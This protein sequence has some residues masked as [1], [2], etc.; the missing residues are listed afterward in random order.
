MHIDTVILDPERTLKQ[1]VNEL[2]RYNDKVIF[3]WKGL[4]LI[5]STYD[6]G[7][8]VKDGGGVVWLSILKSTGVV[9]VAGA[10]W[11]LL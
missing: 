3:S 11:Q 4:W 8:V 10:S 6:P 7:D 1:C 9:P 2:N 5:T